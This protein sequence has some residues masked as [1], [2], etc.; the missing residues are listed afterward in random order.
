MSDELITLM[1]AMNAKL[2]KLDERMTALEVQPTKT[3]T[4]GKTAAAPKTFA[5]EFGG[6]FKDNLL[7]KHVAVTSNGGDDEWRAHWS[8]DD[9]VFVRTDD[10]GNIVATYDTP[11]EF[12]TAHLKELK[13]A[14]QYEHSTACAGWDKV[15]FRAED[16]KWFP[17]DKLR[18]EEMK[19]SRSVSRSKSRER[20]GV[21]TESK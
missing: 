11:S 8:A 5:D 15:K 6:L 3:P 7:I 20:S 19:K 16:K 9:K 1:R 14:K 13:E 2:D 10:D 18:P 17:L 4:K 12:G 21:R